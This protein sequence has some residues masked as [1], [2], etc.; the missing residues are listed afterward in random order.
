[1]HR[2][3]SV[4]AAVVITSLCA[5]Q[6]HAEPPASGSPDSSADA[7]RYGDAALAAFEA[8]RYDEAVENFQRAFALD[9]NPNNL[10]NIGRVYEEAGQLESAVEYYKQFIAQPGVTLDYRKVALDRIEVLEK[11]IAAT[12]PQP[13]PEPEP[14]P[15]V[16][17]APPPATVETP[18]EDTTAND[19][20]RKQ[21]IAGLVLL[22]VGGAALIGG[23]V[24]G[25]LSVGTN[26]DLAGATPE[27][28]GDLVNRGNT[29]T[30]TADVLFAA[31]G[32]LALVGLIVTLTALPKSGARKTAFAPMFH[33]DGGGVVVMHRF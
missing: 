14:E 11:T 18:V 23:G 4:V 19:Q 12:K 17:P 29:L 25:G 10:F 15:E 8:G 3:H 24:V 32:T 2:I 6:V 27:Q 28:R 7:Q 5:G 1:M 33:R 26:S 21:R 31:G 20:R 30:T 22:G 9:K 16:E 13:E